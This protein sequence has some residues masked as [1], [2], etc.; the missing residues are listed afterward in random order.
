MCARARARARARVRVRCVTVGSD[1]HVV[2]RIEPP[3]LRA[4]CDAV[5][6]GAV[7]CS[8]LQCGV[9]RCS[10]VHCTAYVHARMPCMPYAYMHLCMFVCGCA[11]MHVG[12]LL[13]RACVCACILCVHARACLSCMLCMHACLYA[14]MPFMH[15][16]MHVSPAVGCLIG[17]HLIP[18]FALLTTKKN[19][20]KKKLA[21][22]TP[23][24]RETAKTKPAAEKKTT[25]P[26]RLAHPAA[27]G[28]LL[29]CAH[30]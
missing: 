9:V 15:A 18:D 20:S 23:R 1:D 2:R 21:Q 6:C 28:A 25:W 12:V 8:V 11:C 19:Q 17:K 13:V 5:R 22:C 10:A 16:H 14:C 4:V 27:N 24:P 3:A 29:P 26:C 7:R 30:A